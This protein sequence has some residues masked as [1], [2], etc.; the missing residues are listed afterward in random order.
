MTDRKTKPAIRVGLLL[1]LVFIGL[2]A[3]AT[4]LLF[5]VAAVSFLDTDK[6]PLTTSRIGA[7]VL[8]ST[9]AKAASV[10]PKI[11]STQLDLAKIP[12]AFEPQGAPTSDTSGPSGVEPAH[13]PPSPDRDASTTT[14]EIADAALT[15]GISAI[16]TRST[17]ASGSE[18]P[19]AGPL[20]TGDANATSDSSQRVPTVMIPAKERH[21]IGQNQPG[22]PDRASPALNDRTAAQI[23]QNP[24]VQGRLPTPNAAFRRR[25][26]TECGPIT[27]PALRRH[28]IAS[29]GIH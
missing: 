8:P 7:S 16:A 12:A 19:T 2:I 11:S 27:F 9:D 29:F 26:Q 17:E 18:H 24:R 6:E 22:K 25:V 10:Q 23:Q 28:C 21:E 20:P 4:I 3:A 14:S 13:E 5:S 1:H 15:P